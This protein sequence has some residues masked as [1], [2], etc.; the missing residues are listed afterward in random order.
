MTMTVWRRS[1]FLFRWVFF[2]ISY[3]DRNE[4]VT[5]E[6]CR[7]LSLVAFN[8]PF[9]HRLSNPWNF[10]MIWWYMPTVQAAFPSKKMDSVRNWKRRLCL[11]FALTLVSLWDGLRMRTGNVTLLTYVPFFVQWWQSVHSTCCWHL[12]LNP[13]L[14]PSKSFIEHGDETITNIP[15]PSSASC[16]FL[17]LLAYHDFWYNKKIQAIYSLSQL[18][19]IQFVFVP[20][21]LFNIH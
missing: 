20:V 15:R 21:P 1:N 2:R 9:L 16:S 8:P 13:N 18:T 12:L 5:I 10:H 17:L 19:P 11:F 3:R 14:H 4:E 6:P 7:V